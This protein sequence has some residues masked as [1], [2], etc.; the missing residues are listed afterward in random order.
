MRTILAAAPEA[1]LGKQLTKMTSASVRILVAVLSAAAMLNAGSV[2]DASIASKTVPQ[3]LSFEECLKIAMEKN[4][5][6]P[7]SRFAVAMAEAQHRQA[8][9]GYW[10]QVS[11]K[12][13]W[14]QLN[15]SPNFV[16]PS[17]MMYIPS[18]TVNVPGGSTLVT[19]PANAFGPGFPPAA[20]QMPVSF[21]GQSVATTPQIFPIPEQDVKLANPQNFTVDGS[22]TWLLYDGGMRRG[23]R[24]QSQGAVEAARAEARRTD[25]QI[26]DSVVRLYY[27]ALLARQLRQ[28]GEDTLAR[29]EVT[30]ELTDSM[31]KNGAGKVNKT[32][33][34]DNLVM[35]ET[36][37]ATVAELVKNEAAAEA[38]LA[39]TMGLDWNATVRPSA[40]ELPYRPYT[41]NLD[42]LVSTAYEFNP[43]WA[44]L[45]AGLKAL[46]GAVA[47]ARSGF[48]PKIALTGDL[49]RW[50]NSYTAGMATPANKEGWSIGVG[51]EI[52]LFDGFLT[53]NKVAE[54]LAR[55]SKLKEEKLLLREGIGLQLREL[56][57]GLDA[58]SKTY[59]SAEKAM[60]A[61]RENR[62]LTSRAYQSELVETEKVIRAQLF[63]ALMTAQYYKARYDLVEIESQI[64]LVVGKEVAGRLDPRR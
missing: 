25:L 11:A 46:A 24:E 44:K 42:E 57:L 47:T 48:F 16:F 40:E 43:D 31:Y 30:L 20:V 27:G 17:S 6:R 61:A 34:L 37:R 26:T 15:D 45:E 53:R 54:A 41:G 13:G 36:I 23:Y 5:Q 33:Y 60:T 52:P 50:W 32:D 10:P 2:A 38:A 49:H 1:R 8:L 35:V 58:A 56:F 29:M 22:L 39:Y 18:Q 3:V 62:D 63:E 51:A 21:P 55:V 7:A 12:G 28:V 19:I 59:Q 4:R 14:T 64:S 9:A